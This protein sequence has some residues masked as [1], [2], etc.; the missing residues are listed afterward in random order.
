MPSRSCNLCKTWL[1]VSSRF[2]QIQ[3]H[4]TDAEEIALAA[5]EVSHNIQGSAAYIR[6]TEPCGTKL[7]EDAAAK[8]HAFSLIEIRD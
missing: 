4:N 8:S 7:L 3:Q 2:R 6:G 1:P 5:G